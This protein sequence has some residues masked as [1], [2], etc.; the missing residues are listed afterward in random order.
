[1]SAMDKRPFRSD[2]DF[3]VRI[4]GE[5]GEGVISCGELFAQ[6]AARTEYHV[7]T[8]I[9]YPAEIRGGF[10]MVQVRI[11]DWTIYSMGNEIDYLVAFNQEAVTGLPEPEEGG[12]LIP[13]LT[14]SRSGDPACL[15]AIP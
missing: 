1:M 5:A 12:M 11:R 14:S 2:I 13:I 4:G 10:S 3:V 6:A 15:P 8:Y 9:T 7:F